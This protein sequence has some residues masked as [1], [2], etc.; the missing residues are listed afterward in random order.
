MSIKQAAKGCDS[1]NANMEVYH[2]H[3]NSFSLHTSLQSVAN[4]D[5]LLLYS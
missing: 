4:H 3:W 5:Y 2:S 1:F